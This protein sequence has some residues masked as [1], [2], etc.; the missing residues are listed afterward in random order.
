MFADNRST[1][2]LLTSR[3]MRRRTLLSAASLF[4]ASVALASCGSISGG[5]QDAP[6]KLP[7]GVPQVTAEQINRAQA[8]L[9][10]INEYRAKKGLPTLVLERHL[11]RAAQWQSEDQARTDG[12]SHNN[13]TGWKLWDRVRAVGYEYRITGETLSRGEADV[14]KTFERWLASPP[15]YKVLNRE[16]YVHAGIGFAW[17]TQ[18]GAREPVWAVVVGRPVRSMWDRVSVVRPAKVEDKDDKKK[19]KKRKRRKRKRKTG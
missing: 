6:R 19:K 10:V 18:R 9:A 1:D 11:M 14:R 15:H 13:T 4:L 16:E 8:M 3:F 17:S 5:D 12:L 7:D 2:R